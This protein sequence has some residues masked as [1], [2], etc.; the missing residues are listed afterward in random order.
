MPIEQEFQS[1]RYDRNEMRILKFGKV[2]GSV[3]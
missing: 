1:N 2:A 3:K